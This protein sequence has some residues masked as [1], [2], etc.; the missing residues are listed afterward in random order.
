MRYDPARD[1]PR[2]LGPDP[3]E[4][5]FNEQTQIIK[6]AGAEKELVACQEMNEVFQ[7]PGWEHIAKYLSEG[8]DALHTLLIEGGREQRKEDV[9]RGK[10]QA[11]RGLLTYPDKN[12]ERAKE[13]AAILNSQE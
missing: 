8:I 5:F 2:Y 4:V 9:M 6:K 10:A 11:L 12:E 13:L 1:D 7:M 3:A